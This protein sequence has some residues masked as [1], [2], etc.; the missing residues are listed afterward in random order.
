MFAKSIFE[1]LLLTILLT[2][3]CRGPKK[4]T[5]SGNSRKAE[6]KSRR[7]LPS[8]NGAKKTMSP[9]ANLPPAA[10][11]TAAAKTPEDP[12]AAK[13]EQLS[14]KNAK[15]QKLAQKP[16]E[17]AQNRENPGEI[18]PKT[19]MNVEILE[20]AKLPKLDATIVENIHTPAVHHRAQKIATDKLIIDPKFSK[21]AGNID[22]IS[23][24]ARN[25]K[26]SDFE[27]ELEKPAAATENSAMAAAS[28]KKPPQQAG[29]V[30]FCEEKCVVF[31]TND[32]PTDENEE[33]QNGE[34]GADDLV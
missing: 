23:D 18:A 13:I 21:Y 3:C 28:G 19:D 31:E 9:P 7:N 11:A 6:A 33:D 25:Q 20:A 30:K 5:E 1:M 32:L 34:G 24:R 8:R 27:K 2:F 10:A 14:K 12:M 17:D 29:R 16:E 4:S 15:S 26:I 22:D